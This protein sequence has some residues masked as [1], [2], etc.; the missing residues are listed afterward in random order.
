MLPIRALS[1]LIAL[2]FIRPWARIDDNQRT[3]RLGRVSART[4]TLVTAVTVALMLTTLRFVVMDRQVQSTL[5]ATVVAFAHALDPQLGAWLHG[6]RALLVNLTWVFGCFTCYFA[7]PALVARAVF[8]V[9]L[10]ETYLAPR[11]YWRKLP[12]YG[13]LFLPV[14]VLVLAFSNTP[15]FLAQYPFYEEHRSWLDLAVWEFGYGVQFFSLEYFFRGFA[16]RGFGAELGA[17]AVIVMAVP[18]CMIHFGKPLPECLG[19]IVAGIVLGTLAMDTRTIWGGVTIH[20][21]VAW[22]MD[23]AAVWHKGGP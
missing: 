17:M 20:V 22:S 19:S 11:D 9:P 2:V 10:Q 6:Y 16:L 7:I 5:A 13:L 14:G 3:P 4:A 21:A 23:L 15:E 18:Y 12:L 8:G 1:A